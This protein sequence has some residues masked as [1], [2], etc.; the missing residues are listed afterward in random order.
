[1]STYINMG[2][3]ELDKGTRSPSDEVTRCVESVQFFGG[4]FYFRPSP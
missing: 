1:M 4:H 2:K 3:V